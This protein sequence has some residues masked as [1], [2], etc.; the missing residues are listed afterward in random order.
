MKRKEM[1][2]VIAPSIITLIVLFVVGN[3]PL[4]TAEMMSSGSYKIQSDSV[5]FGGNL[6]ESP[7]YTIEDTL[8]EV[9]TGESSS[10]S[11]NLKAGY[12]QMHEVFISMTSPADVTMSPSLAGLTGGTSNG[13]TATTITTDS[14]AGYQLMIKASSSPAL[15]GNSS[16]D[17]ISDYTP[18]G[19]NPDFTFSVPAGAGEFGFTPE[20]T[21]IAQ[22]YKDDG[23]ACNTGSGDT[24]DAC[25]NALSTSNETISM[26]NSANTPSGVE[27]VIKFRVMLAT[28]NF[29][30]EDTYTAT[31]TLTALAL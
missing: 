31:S 9:A 1:K 30:L 19:A 14:A 16:G 8:G 25:W 6:G 29:Q 2:R 12:Q 17:A 26:R 10:A 4:I 13:S 3:M 22:E 7:S 27:T 5:N 21:D 28:G 24:A 20:G 15:A 11:Y 18:A 23:A